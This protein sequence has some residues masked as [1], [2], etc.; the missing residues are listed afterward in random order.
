MQLETRRLLLRVPDES[1]VDAWTEM[2]A[3]P[4]VERW[5]KARTREQVAEYIRAIRERHAADGFGILAAVRKHDR[6]VVGRA[7]MLVWDDRTWTPTTL[8]EAGANGEVEIGWALHPDVWGHGYATEASIPCR[9]FV[10]EHV[11]PRVIALIDPENVRSIAVAERLG[12]S[13][14][15]DVLQNGEKSMRVYA[16]EEEHA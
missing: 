15:R 8:R 16:I 6:R 9:D 14:E 10:L 2:Y 12:L 4:S 13:H 11:R 1:D 7:G 3:Q 5:L